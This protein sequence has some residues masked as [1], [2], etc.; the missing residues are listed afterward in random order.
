MGLVQKKKKKPSE[1]AAEAE[2]AAA[3][4]PPKLTPFQKALIRDGGWNKE[5]FPEFLEAV[6][7]VRQIIA[8][9]CGIVWGVM[10]LRGMM[11]IVLF[12]GAN[13]GGTYVYYGKYAAVDEEDFGQVII[14]QEGLWT[15]VG[16]F[17]VTWIFTFTLFNA[18]E[19]L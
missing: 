4:A 12:L 13:L 2:A 17:M 9:V 19:S 3:A 1:K 6:Y 8:L 5:S 7:W 15:S 11:G 14:T 18:G 10:P 16:L